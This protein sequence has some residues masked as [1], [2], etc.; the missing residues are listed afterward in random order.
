MT[1]V[2]PDILGDSKLAGVDHTNVRRIACLFCSPQHREDLGV[3]L[4]PY[5]GE[6]SS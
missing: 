1:A 2:L 5:E 4:A 3:P 6:Q